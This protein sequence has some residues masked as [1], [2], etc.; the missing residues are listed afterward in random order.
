MITHEQK[1]RNRTARL[2]KYRSDEDYRKSTLERNER[3]TSKNRQ[4][5][6]EY[7]KKRNN[8]HEFRQKRRNS[9]VK[10]SELPLDQAIRRRKSNKDYAKKNAAVMRSYWKAY[11][12]A[13][14]EKTKA[15]NKANWHKRRATILGA[16]VNPKSIKIFILGVKS[17][18]F[19]TCYYCERKVPTTRIAFDH[20]LAL[21]KGG[22]NSVEN[23]CVSC[24]DCNQTKHDK[25]LRDF[26]TLGQQLLE[27]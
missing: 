6:L 7:W 10:I 12:K 23:L 1:Q 5:R 3:W 19:A 2:S 11:R 17:K 25:L 22:S 16:T 24:S 8:S 4:S 27:L 21:S 14:P 18:R 20:I 9:Y 15:H 13:H 26:I